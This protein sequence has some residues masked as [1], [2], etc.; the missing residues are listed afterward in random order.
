M[1]KRLII[2]TKI[3][4]YYIFGFFFLGKDLCLV[5]AEISIEK[6]NHKRSLALKDRWNN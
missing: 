1:L 3:A 5:F 6:Q 4:S 2:S